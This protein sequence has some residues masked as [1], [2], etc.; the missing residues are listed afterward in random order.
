MCIWKG[1]RSVV[2]FLVWL[3]LFFKLGDSDDEDIFFNGLSSANLSLNGKAVVSPDGLLRLTSPERL[4]TGYAF[5]PAPIRFRSSPTG[6]ISSFSSAFVFAIVPDNKGIGGHGIAFVISPTKDFRGATSNQYF[7]IF[8]KSSS[9]DEVNHIFAVELDTIHN[10]DMEDINDNHVGID[11]NSYI[12]FNSSPAGYFDDDSGR[13]NE[14][15]LISGNPLQA[16]VDYDASERR[17]NITLSPTQISKPKIPLIS[18]AVDLTN[19]LSETMYVGFSSST[20]SFRTSHYLLGWSFRMNGMARALDPST[21]PPL[22]RHGSSGRARA[23]DIW[24]PIF[25]PVL[26]MIICAVVVFLVIRRIKF[27]E[28]F[29]EWEADFSSQRISYK[30]LY[31][32]TKGFGDGRLLGTGGFGRVYRGVM[33]GSKQAIAVKIVAQE[34]T[35]GM[36]EFIREISTIGQLR[37]RNLVQLLGYC[38]RKGELLLV[39]DFM[40]NSSLDKFLHDPNHPTLSWAQRFRVVKDVGAGLLYMHEEWEMSII[41]RDIKASNVLLDGEF[42]GRLGDF[43]LAR[44]Y[45]NEDNNP[46]STRMVGT[47][48]YLAPELLTTGVASKATDVFSFGAFLLEVAC[49]RRPL[50]SHTPGEDFTLVAW[51]LKNW[52]RGAIRESVDGRLGSDYSEEEVELVL[53]L[54]LLC[55]HYSPARRPCMRQVVQYLGGAAE[56]PEL[57]EYFLDSNGVE[58]LQTEAIASCLVSSSPSS[59]SED[60]LLH[61]DR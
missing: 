41:H 56:L 46:T 57:V 16:W 14:L 45:D 49:G 3:F 23:A 31:Y 22:P 29:E 35:R 60:S 19:V 59:L 42:N 40:P 61:G 54:G 53:K 48:G 47:P 4:Q 58:S 17:L 25:V 26:A 7:G 5:F 21:L 28:L 12:S 38:R 52:R 43:S 37:H 8:N 6:N 36:K 33:P 13:F 44:L 10:R 30:D 34:S 2:K 39:Y 15:T 24:V 51:L 18:A 27:S 32:A 1:Q 20:G 50:D 9:R 55:S 11:I